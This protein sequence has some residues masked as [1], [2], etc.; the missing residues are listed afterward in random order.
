M[1]RLLV[2]AR[3][4][5]LKASGARLFTLRPV[6]TAAFEPLHCTNRIRVIDSS[7]Q[8]TIRCT[9]IRRGCYK[10][11]RMALRVD[12][13]ALVPRPARGRPCLAHSA[14]NCRSDRLPI[15]D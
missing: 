7:A 12:L 11:W 3:R 15:A 1:G 10:R 2:R 9:R 4:P 6:L 13:P 8:A 14:Q 5:S